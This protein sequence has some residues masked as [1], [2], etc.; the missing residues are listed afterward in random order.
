MTKRLSILFLLLAPLC[1]IMAQYRLSG[2]YYVVADAVDV[3]QVLIY[4][5]LS[6][7]DAYIEYNGAGTPIWKT[8]AGVVK[9][10]G[11]GAETLYPEDGEGYLL[12]EGETLLAS[13]FVLDYAK[14]ALDLAALDLTAEMQC[15]KSLLTLSGEVPELRYTTTT[16][17][18]RVISR[19]ASV[20]YTSLGW[21]EEAWVDSLITEE[22]EVKYGV[23]SQVLE[24]GA[25]YTNTTFTLYLDPFVTNWGMDSISITSVE[26]NAVAVCVHPQSV[27]TK[28]GDTMENEPM[29]PID[30]STL[31]GSAP[32]D[33]NFLSNANKPVALYF[34]WQIYKGTDLIAERFDEDQRYTFTTNGAYQVKLWAYNDVCTT[35]SAVFDISV[36]ESL[37]RVPNVFTPNG[38]GNND[39]FRV[40]YRSLAEFHC[41]V[42][43]RWGQLVYKWD[44]PAKGWDGRINGK[45]A[46]EGAYYYIIRAR[47]TD[48]VPDGKYHKATR[49]KPADIGVYQ[50]SGHINLIRGK[51]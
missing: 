34:K 47:G 33:I 15:D 28:R 51:K 50:L 19:P 32:L 39:E 38:D 13:F 22:V 44:D 8:F 27:T 25:P 2:N 24:V 31:Q 37:L 9:Q 7:T 10:Q 40:V 45:P 35:D 41:W 23:S 30:E 18:T 21:G 48:A 20:S 42:Y 1:C 3:D 14:H 36:S 11:A 29:R 12:Y 4:Q 43:N 16:G 6:A 17:G 46:A 49:K 5:D 26:Q